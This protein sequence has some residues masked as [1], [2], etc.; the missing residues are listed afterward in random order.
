MVLGDGPE[1]GL[2]PGRNGALRQGENRIRLPTRVLRIHADATRGHKRPC[3]ISAAHGEMRGQYEPAGSPSI[4]R[5]F[6]CLFPD[7]GIARNETWPGV[8]QIT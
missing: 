4:P 1:I 6:N 8:R 3:D 5:R 7:P 2:L